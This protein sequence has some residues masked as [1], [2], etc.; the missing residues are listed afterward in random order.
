MSESLFNAMMKICTRLT[1][2]NINK[3]K[4]TAHFWKQF[5]GKINGKGSTRRYEQASY[6]YIYI[7]I[8]IYI[9]HV[10]STTTDD[11]FGYF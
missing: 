2:Q 8:Y 4:L 10:D 6:Q 7:Y 11:W 5:I 1:Y 3:L 9:T